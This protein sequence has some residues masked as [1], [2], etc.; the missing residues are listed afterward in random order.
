M[1]NLGINL[2][3]YRKDN[4][5][6]NGQKIW[7]GTSPKMIYRGQ[8]STTHS[9][10]DYNEGTENKKCDEYVEKLKLSHIAGGI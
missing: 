5:T 7:T 10:D 2:T 9:K 3:K 4:T 8:I 6:K 1:K